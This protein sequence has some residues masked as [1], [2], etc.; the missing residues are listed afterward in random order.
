MLIYNIDRSDVPCDTR[1]VNGSRG[2]VVELVPLETCQ[3][4][5]EE[6]E[7][8]SRDATIVSS[9][10]AGGTRSES[11]ISSTMPRSSV[12]KHYCDNLITKMQGLATLV[13]PRVQFMNGVCKV[14]SPCCFH[15]TLYDG[16][17]V[18]RLQLPIKCRFPS[19]SHLIPHTTQAGMVLDS[20]QGSR[21]KH[22]LFGG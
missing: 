21:R 12:L 7:R 11:S 4:E 22:R 14:L 18:F 5:L 10:G 19:A 9:T 8:S 16:G 2:I 13:F 15:Q 20:A 6:E 17:Y 3:R 1:L